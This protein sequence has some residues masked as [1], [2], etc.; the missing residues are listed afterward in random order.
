MAAQG[1]AQPGGGTE[2]EWP[3]GLGAEAD[4]SQGCSSRLG[5]LDSR[6][7]PTARLGPRRAAAV[8]PRGRHGHPHSLFPPPSLS[9]VDTEGPAPQVGHRQCSGQQG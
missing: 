4:V 1:H 7:A 5:S 2:G 9:P 6:A 8:G 3:Q